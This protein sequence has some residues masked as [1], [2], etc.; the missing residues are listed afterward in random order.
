[1]PL[2][3]GPPLH[4]V[5]RPGYLVGFSLEGFVQ[6]NPGPQGSPKLDRTSARSTSRAQHSGRGRLK[7]L[8][9]RRTVGSKAQAVRYHREKTKVRQRLSV[10]RQKGTCC[11]RLR[12]WTSW[13][14]APV[15]TPIKCNPRRLTSSVRSDLSPRFYRTCIYTDLS[16]LS[17]S[18]THTHTHTSLHRV[19][20]FQGGS[21]P[22]TI[23]SR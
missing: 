8:G 23:R 14:W 7:M 16:C 19:R 20:S 4:R 18:L 10:S 2:P 12:D 3:A 6:L 9:A 15:A 22:G 11:V 5:F 1:M 13:R 21:G 17:L